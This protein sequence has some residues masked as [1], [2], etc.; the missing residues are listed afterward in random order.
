MGFFGGKKKAA[1]LEEAAEVRGA[2]SSTSAI[3]EKPKEIERSAGAGPNVAEASE[4]V[5]D[6]ILAG[7]L[8]G[9]KRKKKE[10]KLELTTSV[11]EFGSAGGNK[12]LTLAGFCPISDE[13]EPCKWEAK[14][15]LWPEL[16]WSR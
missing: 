10:K 1:P 2:E 14:A 13:H 11:F 7:V 12:G 15:M 3:L 16:K 9:T 4:K 6:E 5:E 8:G